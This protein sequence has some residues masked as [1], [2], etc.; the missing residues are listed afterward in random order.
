M[1]RTAHTVSAPK[2]RLG[3]R[4]IE[5]TRALMLNAAMRLLERSVDD[6]SDDGLSFVVSNIRVT[7]VVA[8]ATR[9]A[10]EELGGSAD[11]YHPFTIG[12][13]YQIWP[14]Q[15]E[16]QAALLFH[17]TQL[18]SQVYPTAETT[19]GHI[20]E[21]IRGE[22]LRDLTMSEAWH[23]NRSDPLARVLLAAYPRIANVQIR[24]A[25][26]TSYASFFAEVSKAWRLILAECGRQPRAPF[27]ETHVARS[28]AALIE[29]FSLQWLSEPDALADPA[30]SADS[31]LAMRAVAALID[32]LTEPI[33]E[34]R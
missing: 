31:D 33:P 17:V 32:S 27:D 16:F 10:A 18:R 2:K 34:D 20:A 29:G 26:A 30:G 25:M 5:Q 7:D 3:R 11:E 23:H 9:L 15:P 8:E 14:T 6:D 28:I 1:A 19:Q 22:A 24:N 13:L 4:P 21:G 12:A